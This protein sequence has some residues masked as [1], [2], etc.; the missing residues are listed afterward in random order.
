MVP[1]RDRARLVVSALM[2]SVLTISACA[3][4]AEP[5][6]AS[7]DPVLTDLGDLQVFVRN[8]GY[9]VTASPLAEILADNRIDL[10]EYET[11]AN[12]VVACLA[13]HGVEASTHFV[14]D[15]GASGFEFVVRQPEGM[16]DAT[17]EAA[18]EQCEASTLFTPVAW[19][20][21]SLVGPT[22]EEN[23]LIARLVDRCLADA[24]IEGGREATRGD[25]GLTDVFLKCSADATVEVLS[26]RGR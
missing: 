7:A 18:V 8:M 16:D 6:E 17:L 2:V 13:E 11:V 15:P 25:P 3:A 1:T 4:D 20:W 22:D 21:A 19:T 14:D 12:D 5:N 9:D 24:G 26:Q 23:E 10:V